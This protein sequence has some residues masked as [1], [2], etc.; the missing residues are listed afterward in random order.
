MRPAQTTHYSM[1]SRDGRDGERHDGVVWEEEKKKMRSARWVSTNE[2]SSAESSLSRGGAGRIYSR[3]GDFETL[4]CRRRSF[5]HLSADRSDW[6]FLNAS[7]AIRRRRG[8]AS[9]RRR[10]VFFFFYFS[11]TRRSLRALYSG[12]PS[13]GCR[14][15]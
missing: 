4:I 1:Q 2:A 14:F 7:L 12:S 13:I 15:F 11:G 9:L 5:S 8:N 6:V 3:L 10:K